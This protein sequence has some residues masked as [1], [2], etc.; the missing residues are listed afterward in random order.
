MS[1]KTDPCTPISAAHIESW[2]AH[3]DVLVIGFGAAGAC[4]A[5]EAH[6]AGARVTIL[7]VASGSGGTTALAGGQIYLGGGTPIQ[8]AC[9]FS[10]TP[11]DMEAYV[12][13]AAG[14]HADDEKIR[15]YCRDSIAHYEWLVSQGVVFNPEY[16]GGKHTNTPEYQ[17][18]AYSGNEKGFR[19]AQAARPAPRA[20]KPKAFWEEGGATLMA[21][22]TRA[23]ER[24]GIE[25][26]YDTRALT[27]IR[28][29]ERVVGVLCRQDGEQRAWH[30]RGGVVLCCGG[31]IM[32]REMIDK[33]APRLRDATPIGGPG[34]VGSGILMGIGAGGAAINMHEGFVSVIWYPSGEFCKGV[35]VNRQGNRF[36]NEDCYHARGAHHC[37]NQPERKV[38]MVV[39]SAIF[40]E[41]P[42]YADPK[43][44]EV[45]ETF[46]ELERDAGFAEG[47]LSATLETYNRFARQGEDPLFHKSAE[48]L[49]PLDQ[50]PYALLDFSIDSGVWYPAFTLGGLDTSVDG[51]VRS[52][53]G[54]VIEGLYAAGRTAAGLPRCAENYASGMSIGDA[55]YFG[56]RAGRA[57]ARDR[58]RPR[59]LRAR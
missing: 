45:G 36:V 32:N 9:G 47:T 4:A 57:A 46:A 26:H 8:T 21:T 3:T 17:S 22:L 43:V 59:V 42:L 25:V 16:Y 18:L 50:P 2:H 30:A 5:L 55:S 20:H 6:A 11:E 1:L 52:A 12:R 41:P 39:D 48:F 53:S 31:F 58:D 29:D 54:G 44:I 51:Q 13:M 28:E 33:Y 27:L 56:R 10:D 38:Y 23:I 15:S 24:A 37:L 35:F 49:R 14:P 40:T 34:D 19:E 7:E